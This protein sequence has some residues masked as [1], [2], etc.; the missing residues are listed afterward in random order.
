MKFANSPPC[1]C[2]SSKRTETSV[3]FDNVGI[4]AFHSFVVVDLGLSLFEW[5]LLFSECVLVFC[6]TTMHLFTGHCL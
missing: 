6:I 1:A 2:R 5:R 3:L 4:L